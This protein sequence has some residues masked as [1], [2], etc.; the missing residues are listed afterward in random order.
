MF[1]LEFPDADDEP[2]DTIVVIDREQPVG[3]FA[4]RVDIAVAEFR[5]ERAAEQ[6]RIVRIEL[7]NVEVVGGGRAFVALRRACRAA[8]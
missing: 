1:L 6:I 7:E 4:R 8:R 2:R 3:Q 5:K